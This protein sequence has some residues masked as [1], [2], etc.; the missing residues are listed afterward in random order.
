MKNSRVTLA[1]AILAAILGLMAPA[2]SF[3]DAKVPQAAN[4]TGLHDFDFLVGQWQVHHRQLKERLTNS[5]EWVEFDGTLITRSLMDGWANM[6]DNV[7]KMPGGDVR[8]VSLRSYDPKTREWAVWWLDGR[9]P[10]ANLD[11]PI[12]GHFENGVGSFY[13]SDNLRGKP[14]RVRVTWSQITSTSARWEQAFSADGGKTWE[15]NWVSE[16]R[17]VS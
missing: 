3:Q 13:S 12:K 6:G 16:F 4:L 17:R 7:F 11:P 1:A 10:S 2:H 14:I 9:N 8:G 15:T 5:R